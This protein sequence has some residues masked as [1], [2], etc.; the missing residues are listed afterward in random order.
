MEG[1]VS[2][3]LRMMDSVNFPE[4][5]LCFDR[6]ILQRSFRPF[7]T[8]PSTSLRTL[9]ETL[10]R[11]RRKFSTEQR[12]KSMPK[13]MCCGTI[14]RDFGMRSKFIQ[15][16][17]SRVAPMI[18]GANIIPM[19]VVAVAGL[20]AYEDT[21]ARQLTGS[22]LTSA[23]WMGVAGGSG[24]ETHGA[25]EKAAPLKYKTRSKG[26][27]WKCDACCPEGQICIFDG[28]YDCNCGYKGS[29]GHGWR[30]SGSK[31]IQDIKKCPS[32]HGEYWL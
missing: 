11:R 30:S 2:V 23:R 17:A 3:D 22:E 31:C 27:P 1:G 29:C 18:L 9:P 5:M 10:R 8:I 14:W 7:T 19:E 12:M 13:S 24:K 21:F 15:Q 20:P 28:W 25:C 26:K 6:Q 32:T 4:E 16:D